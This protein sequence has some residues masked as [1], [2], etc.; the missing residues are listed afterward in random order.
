MKVLIIYPKFYVYGGGEVLLVRLCNY[1]TR[2][3]IKNSILTTHMIPEIE[4]DL[5]ETEV[6]IEKHKLRNETKVIQNEIKALKKGLRKHEG[7]YD[8]I[9]PHNFPT[10]VA[11][12]KSSKPVVWMC[13]EPELYLTISHDDFKKYSL[14]IKYY[15]NKLFLYEKVFL[16]K[17][18]KH[19]VVSDEYNAQRF[20]NIYRFLPCVIHYGIDYD[21]FSKGEDVN[22]DKDFLNKFVVLH[23][24]MFTPFKNQLE[25]LRAIAQLKDTI[26]NILLILA[27]G[28]FDQKYKEQ[29]EDYVKANKLDSHV[30]FKGHIN[31]EELRELYYHS[32]LM[33]HPI[34]SQGG[35][36][37]PFEMLSAGKPIIVS[38]EMT[39]SYIIEREN[40]GIVTEDYIEAILKIYKDKK[41]YNLM[42]EQGKRFVRENLTWDNFCSK[43]VEIYSKSINEAKTSSKIF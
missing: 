7:K 41:R 33:I 18:I 1:L 20:M 38:T 19:A 29:C 26:P 31:R 2:N 36:L 24:G 11:A 4:S 21:Y 37:S 34:K 16:K 14:K 23:V 5:T 42:A 17:N 3:G 13:N 10:E 25:S 35:W 9:N 30:L 6:I 22:W 12:M 40:I 43:M 28:G 32:D 8:I 39:S 27:G 15:Y